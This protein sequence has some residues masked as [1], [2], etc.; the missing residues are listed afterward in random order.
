MDAIELLRRQIPESYDW[1]EL[2][3]SDVTQDQANWRP[4]GT[5]NSIASTY[6]HLMIT[7]DAGFNTQL[8]GGMPIMATEFK[9]QVGL[10]EM[11]HAAGGWQDWNNLTVDW[12]RLQE[13]GRAVR[14]C[15]DRYLEKLTPEELELPVDMR[16]WG[17][18]VWKGLEI[19]DLHGN[20][21]VRMHG[22]EIACLK[23]LQGA[24]GYL[25]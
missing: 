21:H 11:P 14:Q 20:K 15:I 17:L 18:G 12:V 5:A 3:V 25:G 24:Q 16:P 2:T 6:A 1:L 8:H 9:G 10:S 23:G 7:A 22:G 13:Y 19:Y 4:P